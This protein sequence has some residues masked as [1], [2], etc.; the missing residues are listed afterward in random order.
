MRKKINDI[1]VGEMLRLRDEGLSNKD[2][3][4][5]LDIHY[6]TVLRWIGKQNGVRENLLAFKEQNGKSEVVDSPP[7]KN[8]A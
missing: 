2:I 1:S 8:G 7:K 4:N 3:A 5:V 6:A